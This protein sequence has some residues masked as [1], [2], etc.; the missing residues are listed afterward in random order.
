METGLGVAIKRLRAAISR[1]VTYDGTPPA[2]RI[3]FRTFARQTTVWWM[4]LISVMITLNHVVFWLTDPLV[5]A[6]TTAVNA[7]AWARAG[8]VVVASATAFVLVFSNWAR[9]RVSLIAATSAILSCAWSGYHLSQ[10]G[11]FEQPWFFLIWAALTMT[12]VIFVSFFHRLLL[13]SAT[14]LAWTLPF[15]IL[16]PDYADY[17]FTFSILVFTLF[18]VGFS[19][20]MG[21]GVYHLLRENYFRRL[22]LGAEKEKSERLLLNILPESIA[23]RLKEGEQPIADRFEDVTVLFGDISGFTGWSKQLSPQDLVNVLN[24]VF[25]EFDRLVDS[26]GLEKIKTIGDAYMVAGGLPQPGGSHTEAVVDMALGMQK[27][28]EKFQDAKPGGL[29][30][31]IGIHTGPVVAG[32]IGEKK[33]VYDLW[34][35]TVNVAS[36]MESH[37]LTG[38]IHVSEATRDKL[39]GL[40]ELEARGVI[41]IKGR[42]PMNTYFV[43]GRS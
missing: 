41:D 28:L 39:V 25:S 2:D 24:R 17:P 10:P 38:R 42:G 11:G 33:F 12:C 8:G 18:C 32:V 37:G 35:D 6:E 36:R 9:E 40:Y 21:H 34:G 23:G 19:S 29:T 26:H 15:F 5:V 14:A 4:V 16:H 7:I 22:A 13:T 27:V 31:R 1:Y 30:M 43:L 20:V 3:G